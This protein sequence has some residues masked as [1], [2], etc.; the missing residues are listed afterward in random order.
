MP[1]SHFLVV[2]GCIFS[3]TVNSIHFKDYT[4]CLAFFKF[5][6]LIISL[7]NTDVCVGAHQSVLDF[8]AVK[9]YSCCVHKLHI[10]LKILQVAGK[11]RQAFVL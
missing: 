1:Q 10:V 9:C 4:L 2:K 3:A 8:L 11:T 5:M 6:P 7:E